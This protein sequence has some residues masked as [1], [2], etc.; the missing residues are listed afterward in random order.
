MLSEATEARLR[1]A[2][3]TDTRID[4]APWQR[5]LDGYELA[6]AP[7]VVD[8]LERFAGLQVVD[9]GAS[10]PFVTLDLDPTRAHARV[11]R[12]S[13]SMFRKALG[14]RLLPFGF[15]SNGNMRLWIARDGTLYGSHEFTLYRA[16]ATVEDG[17]E[18][19]LFRRSTLP[20]VF[21]G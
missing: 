5:L 18:A 19:L 12:P 15:A 6:D 14:E 1:Q 4:V 2:G 13:R 17:L 16:G 9:E 10:G 21:Q 3:W 8:A 20:T 7:A 11:D